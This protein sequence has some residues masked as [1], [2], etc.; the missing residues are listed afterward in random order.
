MKYAASLPV[1][2][3]SHTLKRMDL[4]T[5]RKSGSLLSSQRRKKFAVS[6][7]NSSNFLLLH[8]KRGVIRVSPLASK[9][10]G[11]EDYSEEGWS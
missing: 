5:A 9:V 10:N 6:Y 4:G 2:P 1:L 3:S 8:L 7:S 11:R